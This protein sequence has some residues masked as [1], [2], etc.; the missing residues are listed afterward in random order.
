MRLPILLLFLLLPI[1]LTA[2]QTVSLTAGIIG[3]DLRGPEV[4]VVYERA[5]KTPVSFREPVREWIE[6]AR[7]GLEYNYRWQ[8]HL[9]M[10]AGLQVINDRGKR[11][12]GVRVPF[13]ISQATVQGGIRYD[14]LTRERVRIGLQAGVGQSFQW[15]T[16]AETYRVALA[17]SNSPERELERR[18]ASYRT[19]LLHFPLALRFNIRLTERWSIEGQ[20]GGELYPHDIFRPYWTTAVSAQ[21]GV[22]YCWE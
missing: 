21:L 7:V 5:M 19:H 16:Y 3:Q 11:V 14:W 4:S 10:F 8:R 15:V 1:A 13:R 9:S 20:A 17:T 2:Q 12:D 6:A 18:M 22:G